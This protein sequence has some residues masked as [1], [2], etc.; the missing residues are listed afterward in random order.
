MTIDHRD[1]SDETTTIDELKSIASRFV[2]DRGWRP[3]HT[4]KNLASSVAIEAAECFQ[5]LAPEE[6]YLVKNDPEKKTAIADE[7]ADVFAY[8]INL[9]DELDV[10]LASEFVRKMRKNAEKYPIAKEGPTPPTAE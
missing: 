4:P 3:Y 5:W 10:D 2:D 1:F 8:L 6:S 9:C 7:I